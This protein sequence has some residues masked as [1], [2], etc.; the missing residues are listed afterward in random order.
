M[1]RVMTDLADEQDPDVLFL[2]C[3]DSRIVPNLITGSGPGDLFTVRNLG[4]LVPPRNDDSVLASI[5]Q[6]V[7]VLSV[8]SI[9]VCGHSGCGAMKAL[10]AGTADPDS[11]LGRWLRAGDASLHAWRSGHP[12]GRRA[13]AAGANDRDALAKVNIA[14]Q[15]ER[16]EAL[17]VVR[18]AVRA[19]RLQVAGLF[20]DVGCARVELLD[21]KTSTFGSPVSLLSGSASAR[22]QRASPMGR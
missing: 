3:V 20:Y 8:R 14:L 10:L 5:E 17:P 9:V 2:T 21:R 16:L 19:G 11:A 22:P 6:A 4:N 18:D 15:L 1:G 13:A 7:D 12:V